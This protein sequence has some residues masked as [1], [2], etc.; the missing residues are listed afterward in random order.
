MTDNELKELVTGLAV[1]QAKTEQLLDKIA[2]ENAQAR[3]EIIQEKVEND[4]MQAKKTAQIQAEN[5]KSRA[6]INLDQEELNIKFQETRELLNQ[7]ARENKKE[8][9]ELRQQIGGLG[10]KF[11]SFT[12]G[13]AFPSMTKVLRKQFG[14]E[15]IGTR[16]MRSNNG[17]KLELDILAYS[18]GKLN[19]VFIVEVKSHVRQEDLQQLLKILK[20]F[21]KVFP[22]HADKKLYAILAY[23]DIPDNVKAKLLKNG[24]YLAMINDDHFKLQIP[25]NF[26]AQCFNM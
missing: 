4:K 3:A 15:F 14:M 20:T 19:T 11:G 6:K 26:Q 2:K 9:K 25:K 23:V 24:I 21:P 17:K 1:A 7:I 12:E 16:V 10:N 13:M 8:N 22:E 18:N 5:A